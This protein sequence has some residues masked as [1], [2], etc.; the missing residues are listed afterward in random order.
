[1]QD[2]QPERE[3]ESQPPVTSAYEP[4]SVTLLGRLDELTEGGV[5]VGE[6]FGFT[7]FS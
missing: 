4:P 6:D 2:I 5:G 3:G 1:M 7:A